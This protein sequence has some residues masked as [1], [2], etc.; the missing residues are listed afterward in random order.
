V[1]EDEKLNEM[2]AGCIHDTHRRM[3]FY[4]NDPY[5]AQPWDAI[6]LESRQIV[7][8]LVKLIRKGGTPA[9]AHRLWVDT[10]K[11]EGW[12]LGKDKD[13]EKK[14]HPA[15]VPYAKLPKWNRKK[16]LVS[17]RMTYAMVHE[18]E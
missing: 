15:M 5:P 17:F 9:E 6:P 3:N 10:M 16:V 11:S 13:P 2:I 12:T 18:G 8:N 1:T 4:L 7:I 14:T